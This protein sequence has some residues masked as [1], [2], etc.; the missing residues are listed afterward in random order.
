[1]TAGLS[2][3]YSPPA[4]EIIEEMRTSHCLLTWTPV[5]VDLLKLTISSDEGRVRSDWE[6][7]II[8]FFASHLDSIAIFEN[9]CH[10]RIA[11]VTLDHILLNCLYVKSKYQ[12]VANIKIVTANNSGWI[13]C[14]VHSSE[15]CNNQF[16]CVN[17]NQFL[18][19]SQTQFISLCNPLIC[20]QFKH[21]KYS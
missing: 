18:N 7:S 4:S 2:F 3:A 5:S 19:F 1:M 12:S 21:K 16:F 13:Q 6:W 10:A 15:T 9:D 17:L 20:V 8:V 14:R 11:T